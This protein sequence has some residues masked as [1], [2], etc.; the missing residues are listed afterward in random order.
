MESKIRKL[1][2]EHWEP[3]IDENYQFASSIMMVPKTDAVAVSCRIIKLES[4]GHT[5]L[6]SHRRAHHVIVLEGVALLETE[7]EKIKLDHLTIVSIPANIPHR[8][9]NN[10]KNK[11]L[12][13]V[14]NIFSI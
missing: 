6:H 11:T 9:T 3:W 8:F 10:S 13:L 2:E 14:Q 7:K 4:G 5:G 12:I 1:K